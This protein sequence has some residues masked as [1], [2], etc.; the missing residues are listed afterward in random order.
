MNTPD[1]PNPPWWR[2]RN[3]LV[4]LGF[5]AIAAYFLYTEHQ[6]HLFGALPFILLALCL[7]LH[8]FGHGGHGG[9]GANDSDA[10]KSRRGGDHEH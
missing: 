8:L 10:G 4:L 1:K 2:S 5:L 3:G 7:V 9:H 6:A